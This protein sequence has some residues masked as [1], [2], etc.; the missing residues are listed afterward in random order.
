MKNTMKE[1]IGQIILIAY[2]ATPFLYAMTNTTI[3]CE[4]QLNRRERRRKKQVQR[5]G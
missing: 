5:M 4:K 1:W 2:V 3:K